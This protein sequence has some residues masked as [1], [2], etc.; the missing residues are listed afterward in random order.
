MIPIGCFTNECSNSAQLS[1]RC[2]LS[3]FSSRM[4]IY[5]KVLQCIRNLCTIPI[6]INIQCLSLSHLGKLHVCVYGI[7]YKVLFTP[8]LFTF[9]SSS[10]FTL[11]CNGFVHD[12]VRVYASFLTQY[13]NM[14]VKPQ[15]IRTQNARQISSKGTSAC[16][17]PLTN[18]SG[19]FCC[20]V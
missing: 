4:W 13:Y 17:D 6:Y 19:I 20:V 3:I 10:S 5:K 2:I 15:L 16:I 12:T 1:T 14:T 7:L 8:I 18:Q 9:F 11:L